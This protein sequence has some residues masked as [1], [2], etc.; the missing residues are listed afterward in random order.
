MSV[1]YD[2]SLPHSYN[3]VLHTHHTAFNSY[4]SLPYIEYREDAYLGW[5]GSAMRDFLLGRRLSRPQS[6][7][8]LLLILVGGWGDRSQHPSVKQESVDTHTAER[9]VRGSNSINYTESVTDLYAHA[10]TVD[11]RCSSPIFQ[12][13][14]YEAIEVLVCTCRNSLGTRLAKSPM[15]ALLNQVQPINPYIKTWHNLVSC[16]DPTLS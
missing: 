14:G 3:T 6:I 9:R 16:P 15:V 11:T 4:S 13:P 8:T 12:A 5:T 7:F 1:T 10:Q 2:S